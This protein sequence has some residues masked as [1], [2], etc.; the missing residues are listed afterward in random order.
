MSGKDRIG[1]ILDNGCKRN[2]GGSQ[3]H[4]QMRERLKSV[5]LQPQRIDCQEDFL[6][7][8][9]RVDTSICAWRYPVGI[10]GHTGIVNVAEIE[11]NCPGLMSADTMARLDISIHTR[12][13]TYDIGSM[14]VWDYNY[15]ISD[16]GHALLRTDW[17]GDLTHLD[18]CFFLESD[19]QIPLRKGVAKR[20]RKAASYISNLDKEETGEE[21]NTKTPEPVSEVSKSEDIS[22]DK[23]GPLVDWTGL[24]CVTGTN[25]REHTISLME[26]CT[27]TERVTQEANS[28]GWKGL[29]AISIETGFDLTTRKGI[30]SAWEHLYRFKPDVL[31]IAWPC[32]PWC[33]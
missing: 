17:F 29:P 1:L 10:H 15:E 6:F 16:S 11:S 28:R 18:P 9:D 13:Q 19:P 33:S 2:V 30:E 27:A 32:D 12:P 23:S 24:T 26:I 21:S 20:L 31:V 7:G 14:N 3:W 5:G 25:P 4:R 8:S 22:L